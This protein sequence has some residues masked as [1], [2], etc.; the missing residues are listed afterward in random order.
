MQSPDLVRGCQAHANLPL[1]VVCFASMPKVRPLPSAGVSGFTGTMG[2]SDSR[3]T[4]RPRRRCV[5]DRSGLSRC[6]ERLPHVPLPLPRRPVRAIR[7]FS[8]HRDGLRPFV[9]GSATATSLSGPARHSLALR[10]VW[11]L[12][13]LKP[14][15]DR[16]FD[17]PGYPDG[18]SGWLPRR[19]DN[20][21]DGSLIRWSSALCVTHNEPTA[22]GVDALLRVGTG[23]A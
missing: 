15:F 10:P 9:G 17:P 12:P 23:V 14:E 8:P 1:T 7:L 3:S 2:L 16:S 20:S 5:G 21:S 13:R 19:T 22:G 18:P 6:A 4:R 11:L